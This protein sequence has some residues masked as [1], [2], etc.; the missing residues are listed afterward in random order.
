MMHIEIPSATFP[1]EFPPIPIFP[2]YL[3]H[4]FHLFK[5]WATPVVDTVL[6]STFKCLVL[7][8]SS[9]RPFRNICSEK[10]KAIHKANISCDMVLS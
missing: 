9:V 5:Y 8:F 1:R 3:I 7:L 10:P 6:C 4:Q 2:I